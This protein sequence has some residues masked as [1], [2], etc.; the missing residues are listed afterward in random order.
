MYTN[1]YAIVYSVHLVHTCYVLWFSLAMHDDASLLPLER[2]SLPAN[3]PGK[4]LDA[5]QAEYRPSRINLETYYE[6][7]NAVGLSLQ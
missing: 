2:G 7:N 5:V 6:I 1:F 4:Q 3:E